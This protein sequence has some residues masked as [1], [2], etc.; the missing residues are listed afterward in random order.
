MFPISMML[1]RLVP[2]PPA[3]S[4]LPRCSRSTLLRKVIG[5]S[6]Q[7]ASATGIVSNARRLVAKSVRTF[8]WAWTFL[9]LHV[10][11]HIVA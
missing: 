8:P 6:S 4:S 7:T 5:P 10:R 1:V 9:L 2:A 3:S 11:T